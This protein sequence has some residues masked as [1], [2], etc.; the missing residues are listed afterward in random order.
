MGAAPSTPQGGRAGKPRSLLFRTSLLLSLLTLFLCR[1]PA[2]GWNFIYVADSRSPD[3]SLQVNTQ[4]LGEVALAIR[5]EAPAFVVFGGD[6]ANF[7]NEAAYREWTNAMSP[8]Y[9]AGI[10]VYPLVG[11]HELSDVPGF[12]AMFGPAIPDNGPPEELDRT[13]A[14]GYSNA[15]VL[16]LDQFMP[17]RYHQVNLPWIESVLSTN[18]RPHVFAVAHEPAFK[19]NRSGGLHDFPAERNR[20]WNLLRMGGGRIYFCG[21]DHFYDRMR[22]DDGDGDPDND[23]W[24][25]VVAT[26]GAPLYPDG[27]AN[28]PNAPWT[29][30]R[31]FHHANYG[32][33]RIDVEE[34]QVTTSWRARLETNVFSAPID[35]MTLKLHRRPVLDV[36]KASFPPRFRWF[37]EAVLQTA[38][39]P[40]GPFTDVPEATS[41]HTLTNPADRQVFFRLRRTLR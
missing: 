21:H 11:N 4:I 36:E 3:W 24:Q 27:P 41:P 20:F 39:H 2:A 8:V 26:A 28:G 32:Y 33:V 1:W 17:G 10:P 13:Y 23:L 19:I 31:V 37:G 38:P 15:L 7:A 40:D 5:K 9:E 6:M 25:L 29:P 34:G 14:I 18:T 16:V 35:T 12:I 22:L 30:V